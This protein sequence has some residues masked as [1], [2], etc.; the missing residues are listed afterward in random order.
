MNSMPN[1]LIVTER[2]WPEDF[3]INDF[4][5]E[6]CRLGY[7]IN[8]FT[9]QPS[10]PLGRIPN[11]WTNSLF[12]KESWRSIEIFRIKTILGYRK[13]L[14]YK[15]FNYLWFAL[16]GS[17][18]ILFIRKHYDRILIYQ[19][20]PL[21]MAIPGFI[22]G[23]V[24]NVPIDIW[25]Q[26]VWPDTVY[27]YGFKKSPMFSYI[28]DRFVSWI[29]NSSN[30]ILISCKGF[31]DVIKRYTT[32]SIIFAPNWPLTTYTIPEATVNNID[33]TSPVFLFAGNI[34]KV[35]NLKNV[36]EG[37]ALAK[38]N[39][40]FHGKLRIAGDGSF[41]E[42]LRFFSSTNRIP[43]DFLGRIPVHLMEKIYSEVDFLILSLSSSPIFKLTI[44]SKFQMYLSV[45]KPILCAAEGEVKYL[46]KKYGLGIDANADSPEAIAK[47]FIDLANATEN[48]KR[49]MR[50]NSKHL[51]AQAFDKEKTIKLIL[52]TIG[53]A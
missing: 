52:N 31:E 8:I 24:R 13:S 44:P 18:A 27:A 11:G 20:G 1:I 3:I 32:K 12:S 7:C 45:G 16:F 28:L 9:Q 49:I 4:A 33:L 35:Q 48:E 25:T 29:Y 38:G 51:L 26:D 2:F 50:N 53:K 22:Y 36:L 30:K 5:I 19:T 41:L 34:G 42:E 15:I 21:T 47:A 40:H 43:V 37:F 39:K 17:L 46:V 14:A 23:K 6:A 10:Y